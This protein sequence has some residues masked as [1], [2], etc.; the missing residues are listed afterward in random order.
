MGVES[1]KRILKTI[2]IV[3]FK[4]YSKEKKYL[5]TVASTTN[6]L[7]FKIYFTL[8]LRQPYFTLNNDM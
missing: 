7:D 1:W 4:A 6:V 8:V 5:H 3:F 2:K